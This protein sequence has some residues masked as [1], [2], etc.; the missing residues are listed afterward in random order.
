MTMKSWPAGA[1]RPGAVAIT[2][3]ALVLGAAIAPAAGE[4]PAAAETP[5]DAQTF[6]VDCELP[7]QPGLPPEQAAGAGTLEDPWRTLDAASGV[8]LGPGDQ[9]LF[10]RGST[11]AGT[12]EL[13]GAG[14]AAAPV[15]IGG[16]GDESAARPAIDG[17]GHD[18]AMLLTN[19]P[20][21][22][23]EDLDLTNHGEGV[24]TRRGLYVVGEDAG[25]IEGVVIRDLHLH[26][27]NGVLNGS[28]LANG[29]FANASGGIIVEV[30]GNSVPTAFAGLQILD[31][32][33]DRVDREGIY[34]WS[35]WMRR[36]ELG[37]YWPEFGNAPW[38]P[39]TGLIVR[40]NVLTD[41][42]GDGIV[43]KMQQDALL[44]HNFVDGFN[45]RS[46]SY[47]VA[48]WA[49]NSDDVLFQHNEATGGVSRLDGMPWDIDHATNR[50]TF[51]YNLS[52]GNEGGWMLLCPTDTGIREATVRWNISIDDHFR[53]IE[54][55]SGPVH[56]A[57]VYNN[58][59]YVGDGVSQTVVNE[60]N[61]NLRNVE[62]FGNVVVKEGAGTAGFTL[63]SGGFIFRDNV[64]SGT[65]GTPAN[66]GGSTADPLLV[67]PG[68]TVADGY[69]LSTGSPALG[70]STIADDDAAHDFF[71]NAL[72][73]E[74]PRNAGAYAGAALE[75]TFANGCLLESMTDA[76]ALTVGRGKT[77]TV[78]FAFANP[79]VDASDAVTMSA[80]GAEG[81]TAELVGSPVIPAGQTA[82]VEVEVSAAAD[83]EVGPREIAVLAEH[84][85]GAVVKAA[86]S[87]GVDAQL[88]WEVAASEDF[89]A[90]PAGALPAS[91]P[92]TGAPTPTVVADAAGGNVLRLQRSST[93]SS[94]IWRF[95]PAEA[96]TRFSVSARAAQRSSALG[97]HWLDA[98]GQTV[99]RLSL[100]EI[101]TVSYTNGSQ[102]VNSPVAYQAGAWQDLEAT[103]IGDR[104]TVRA[105]DVVVA[106]AAVERPGPVTALRLQMPSGAAGPSFDVDGL[107]VEQVRAEPALAVEAT[108][109]VRCLGSRAYVAVRASN[110]EAE[111]VAVTLRTAFGE[112][113]FAAVAPG[114]SAFHVF[115]TRSNAVDPGEA[116]VE[117]TRASD[118]ATV[119]FTA[120]YPAHTCS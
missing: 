28:V 73:T 40:G 112:K 94:A 22:V 6:H 109:S 48:M 98:A 84:P 100:N 102:W 14:S 118:G 3:T 18:Q 110:G 25:T 17:S 82:D 86:R 4:T 68:S 104:Y 97:L 47:N 21:V 89:D 38:F 39:S 71:G 15:V 19:F 52:Y 37:N 70:L 95:D 90:L 35:S 41:I 115:T 63:R 26:D 111:P 85:S 27:I 49:A 42:G 32:R 61:G 29:K 31:N 88:D 1:I 78:P 24:V 120:A 117:A 51:Q 34:T 65:T 62:F 74:G 7:A 5:A 77:A 83:A 54:T 45:R 92:V 53:G 116:T 80:V 9:L 101:G 43:A 99:I 8:D 96:P 72:S 87:V 81:V 107:V 66:P 30:K 50:V 55:C 33:L 58:T 114:A 57:R 119:E 93:L 64:F 56:S 60:N 20:H 46:G 91:W 59:I 106:E 103:I 16:Y 44:E 36:A 23:I 76:A 69:R 105:G 11:C 2:A 10:H 67:G 12:I 108:A 75:R 79:C 13:T 113:T